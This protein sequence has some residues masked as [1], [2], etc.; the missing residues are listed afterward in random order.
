[1]HL[2]II[3][4]LSRFKLPTPTLKRIYSQNVDEYMSTNCIT[5]LVNHSFYQSS[6]TQ[7]FLKK[8]IKTPQNLW[9][10]LTLGSKGRSFYFSFAVSEVSIALFPRQVLFMKT[11]GIEIYVA[12]M[13]IKYKNR[14]SV[15][16]HISLDNYA[17]FNTL[18]KNRQPIFCSN[19]ICLYLS[20]RNCLN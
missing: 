2:P 11:T 12:T 17:M 10:L 1:M 8:Q 16:G 20:V 5:I 19:I 18:L 6:C 14:H 7:E 3:S 9:K 4:K 15:C 13:L